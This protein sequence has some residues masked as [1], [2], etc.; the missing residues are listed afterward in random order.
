MQ[1]PREYILRFVVVLTSLII[2]VRLFQ[3]Q[4][5]DDSYKAYAENNALRKMVQ[6]PPRGEIYDRNGLFLAQSKE[7][8]DL[9][10]IPRDL[11]PFDTVAFCS[12]VGVTREEL[13][14]GLA[15]A[16]SYSSRRPSVLFKQLSKETK[17]KFEEYG[18]PG[19]YTQFRT[20]RSYPYKTAGNILGYVG[21]VNADHIREDNYYKSG[22]YIGLA[23][24]ERAYET[25]LR[26][27]KGVKMELVDVHGM[28]KG[29]YADGLYDTMAVPG[30]SIVSTI[31]AKLQLLAEEL[32]E[33][34]IGS[35]LA[36]EPATGE[37]LVMV[38]SPTYNPDKLIGRDRS[39]NY[40][41]LATDPRKPMFNRAV[42][43]AYPPGS[44][45]KIATG[46]I[47]LQEGVLTPSQ[48]YP[49]SNGY[50]FGNLHLGCHS[51]ASPLDLS[52]AIQT[53]CNAYFC[54]VYRNILEN[55]RYGDVKKGFDAWRKHVLSFGFGRK[56]ESDFIGERN[57]NIP[58]REY[59]D[60][61][62]NGRW[63]SLTTLSLAIGQ[64]EI[65]VSPLQ[66]ANFVATVANRGYYYIPHIVKR[67]DGKDSIDVR[68]RQKQYTDIDP[69]Y[70]DIF[71]E[72]M[73]KGVHVGGTSMRAM[74]PGLDI[75]GKTGTAE[76]GQG[77]DHST[78][79]AFAPKDHPKIAISVYVE[80]GGFGA[81]IALPIASLLIE[82]Y[83]TDTIT[84]P[85]E[86]EYVKNKR[87]NYP[88]YAK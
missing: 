38:S 35:V 88:Q 22:D 56:L 49:C 48:T 39:K 32:M 78:F 55:R 79:A 67:I 47:G 42:M 77:A 1:L 44:T 20:I 17:L 26:G 54:Y 34:K 86:V 80:H 72:A 63:N 4:I 84:R 37:I 30:T 14:E 46:L 21:E 64:G 76:N 71:A 13:V 51:H 81:S 65:G 40:R 12:V 58:S 31:D 83:L 61:M 36:I 73:W 11:K 52:F 16:R 9:M 69:K 41:E 74:V 87:I 62:Y 57:G 27:N 53:S 85:A 29:A 66:L 6:Y 68:F 3:L 25:V 45:F 2:V 18:F 75:C 33:G 24:I 10:V 59:Y 60:R 50:H 43:A 82:Q 7:A 8:Y 19:M 15:K 70:F 28:P 23:G 5:V